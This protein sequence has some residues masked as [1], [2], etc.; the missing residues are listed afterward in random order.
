MTEIV[1]NADLILVLTEIK[2]LALMGHP[3]PDDSKLDHNLCFAL[4]QI[5]GICDRYV[6][7]YRE[8][9]NARD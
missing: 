5:G 4:G 7:A 3:F 8:G 2:Q 6:D 9:K 1:T